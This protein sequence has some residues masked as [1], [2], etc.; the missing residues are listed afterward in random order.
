MI[1]KDDK[2]RIGTA[3]PYGWVDNTFTNRL[4]QRIG[5]STDYNKSLIYVLWRIFELHVIMRPYMKFIYKV[6]WPLRCTLGFH[7]KDI[8]ILNLCGE[9]VPYCFWCMKQIGDG[10]YIENTKGYEHIIN[11]TFRKVG[12]VDL[13]I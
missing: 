12:K 5:Y 3:E 8:F 11:A 7:Q 4:V 2:L 10:F 6:W 9:M 13:K 1:I